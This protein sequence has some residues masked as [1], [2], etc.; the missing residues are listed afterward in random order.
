MMFTSCG[1]LVNIIRGCEHHPL[2]SRCELCWL[3]QPHM[4]DLSCV[5]YFF[6]LCGKSWYRWHFIFFCCERATAQSPSC[7]GLHR[8]ECM[9]RRP[10]MKVASWCG[11]ETLTFLFID[12]ISLC[13]FAFSVLSSSTLASPVGSMIR[14]PPPDP[15]ATMCPGNTPD[16]I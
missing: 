9:F 12:A 6:N 5:G 4:V 13:N 1:H 11:P 7:L 3:F 15:Q 16:E 10:R 2:T 8:P 14:M